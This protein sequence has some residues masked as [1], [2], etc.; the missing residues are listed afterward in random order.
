MLHTNEL[1]IQFYFKQTLHSLDHYHCELSMRLDSSRHLHG[2]MSVYLRCNQNDTLYV[3][4][5]TEI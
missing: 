4:H 3:A 2:K 5:I 1:E